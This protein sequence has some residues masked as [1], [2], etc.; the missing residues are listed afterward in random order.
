MKK[1]KKLLIYISLFFFLLSG[2]L[3][4]QPQ[5]QVP[6]DKLH[7]EQYKFDGAWLPDHDA[8]EIGP[9][10]FKFLQ[11]M[12]YGPNHPVG[13]SGYTK[14]NT[15]ALSTYTKIRS[16]H[17]LRTDRTKKTYTLVNTEDASGNSRVYQNQTSI[18]DQGDFEATEL[19]TDA[20]GAGL[21]RFSDAPQGNVAYCNEKESYIWPGE[22]SRVG[23]VFT[24]S[25]SL[26]SELITTTANRD[27]SVASDW[28]NVDIA[29]YDETDNL[30]L[31]ADASGQY[32]TLAANEA[33]MT[34]GALYRITFDSAG[35]EVLML[36]CDGADESTTF[37]D[38]SDSG[39]T[40]TATG[41]EIDT[42]YKK[43]GSGSGLFGGT[44]YLTIPDHP[45]W[46]YGSDRFAIDF[47]IY[48][49]SDNPIC[50]LFDQFVDGS[51]RWNLRMNSSGYLYFEID[52]NTVVSTSVYGAPLTKDAWHHVAVIR[53][54]GG[55]VNDWA[56]C[57]DG[58][59]QGT[60]TAATAVSDYAAI[61]NIGRTAGDTLHFYG[62]L[63]E[64]R[65]SKGVARWTS[66][67]NPETSRSDEIDWTV[68]DVGDNDTIATITTG[69]SQSIA[70]LPSVAGGFRIESNANDSLS[71]FDN[72]SLKEVSYA[73]PIDYTE[74]AN[75]TLD[76]ANNIIPIGTQKIWM[77]F[78][79]KPAQGIKYVVKTANTTASTTICAVWTGDAFTTVSSLSDGTASGGISLAQNGSFSF[80]ST[81]ATAKPYHLE[82]LYL[83]A[84]LFVLS[85]G[86]AEISHISVDAPWQPVVDVWDGVLRQPIQFQVESAGDF[87]DYTLAVNYESDID[88]PIG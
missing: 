75:N 35:N 10:N 64:I 9:S 40:A 23:A 36:H 76:T 43:F 19:H 6:N 52:G 83:Y 78:T 70:Y 13:T 84:Y 59:V 62:W 54:W 24:L 2:A 73:D 47:W 12:R 1:M 68:K 69:A 33:P 77:V 51:N 25:E 4:Q 30:T 34:A 5:A 63:D 53:G 49:E 14:I 16:G 20:T 26:S 8:A 86:S 74:Q 22:E 11:N 18:P 29:T 37:T 81:V 57:I 79:T 44:D 17:Q 42:D 87:E 15:T 27:F 71:T 48:H 80:D 65:I 72:F 88:I 61:L 3:A 46:F 56:I 39:H 67:F 50:Y 21:G 28:T 85:D 41:A 45:N 58:T 7:K 31:E 82:G 32:C 55:N 66:N 60:A 38:S